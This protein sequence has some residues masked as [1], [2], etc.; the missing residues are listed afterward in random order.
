VVFIT[1]VDNEGELGFYSGY[2]DG[3]PTG[4][5]GPDEGFLE[6]MPR[7]SSTDDAV[8][9]AR[10]RS[11]RVNIRPSWDPAHYYSAGEKPTRHPPLQRPNASPSAST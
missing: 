2:W 10:S 1:W 3:A 9:W 4:G 11:D 6:Q 8:A 5:H 7:T